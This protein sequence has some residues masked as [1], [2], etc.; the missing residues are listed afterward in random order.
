MTCQHP[1]CPEEAVTQ[2]EVSN[3]CSNHFCEDHGVV[4]GDRDGDDTIAGYYV[5]S[6]CWACCPESVT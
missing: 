3:S 6:A 5:P 1:D 4:G 2:C